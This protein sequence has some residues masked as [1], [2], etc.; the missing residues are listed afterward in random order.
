M[1]LTWELIKKSMKKNSHILLVLTLLT[2]FSISI[3]PSNKLY[4]QLDNNSLNNSLDPNSRNTNRTGG[5][6]LTID[7]ST[8]INPNGGSGVD[9]LDPSLDPPTDP[10]GPTDPP[11]D[12][13]FDNGIAIILIIGLATGYVSFKPKMSKA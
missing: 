10:G 12:V 1:I 3:I 5:G 11:A 9:P 13:P 4:A 2:V 8:P 7:P 6:S